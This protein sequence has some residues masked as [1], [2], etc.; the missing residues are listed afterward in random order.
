MKHEE[1]EDE[2]TTTF[3]ESR[4]IL[5]DLVSEFQERKSLRYDTHDW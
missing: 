2:K 5:W 4:R 3:N 1:D